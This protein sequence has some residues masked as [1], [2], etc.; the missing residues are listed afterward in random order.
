MVLL[1]SQKRVRGKFLEVFGKDFATVK[2]ID[3][4]G[5]L[6]DNDIVV[7]DSSASIPSIR[8]RFVPTNKN[9]LIF[10]SG[11]PRLSESGVVSRKDEFAKVMLLRDIIDLI[12]R[13][14]ELTS[15]VSRF[16]TKSCIDERT[17]VVEDSIKVLPKSIIDL[18]I[19]TVDRL[20]FVRKGDREDIIISVSEV[21]DN[22]VEANI[23]LGNLFCKVRLSVFLSEDCLEINLRDYLGVADMYSVASSVEMGS[24]LGFVFS[25]SEVEVD[26]IS[27]RGRGY[28][29]IS[30]TVDSFVTKIV[31][32]E[33]FKKYGEDNSYTETSVG[34]FLSSRGRVKRERGVGVV[35]GFF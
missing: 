35:I 2:F 3:E 4:V 17:F 33:S 11:I 13:E 8:E 30:K 10:I 28:M 22:I 15:R 23:N 9:V 19:S 29:L 20:P 6:G 7:T 18:L 5:A 34:Y 24:G 21:L 31:G 32:S 16:F 12:R 26:R 14:G 25:H 27:L 1:V